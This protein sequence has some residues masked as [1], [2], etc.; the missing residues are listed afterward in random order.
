MKRRIKPISDR[1][2]ERLKEYQRTKK[3]WRKGIEGVWC[4]VMGPIFGR[5]VKVAKSPHHWA[6][7]AGELLCESRLFIAVSVDG[8]DWIHTH[9]DE[10]RS[11]GLLCPVGC[12]ND[13]KRAIDCAS[14]LGI[15]SMNE[16][17]RNYLRDIGS[18]GGRSGTGASKS[19]TTKQAH[20]AAKARWAKTKRKPKRVARP[21][22]D[23]TELS[24]RVTPTTHDNPKI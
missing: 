14:R 24:A 16:S 10:A 22:N 12:W 23:R 17:V 4:P 11:L 6:G 19:R 15:L 3:K 9:M 20:R 13:Y 21:A 18:K 2:K 8:H 1:Q 5:K 7:R